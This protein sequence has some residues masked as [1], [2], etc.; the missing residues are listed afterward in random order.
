MKTAALYTTEVINILDFKLSPCSD[1]L[2]FLL[3]DSPESSKR[4]NSSINIFIL[5]IT[6]SN[7]QFRIH[8]LSLAS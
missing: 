5:Q 1:I 3:G 8:S 2:F 4:K 6:L 7:M